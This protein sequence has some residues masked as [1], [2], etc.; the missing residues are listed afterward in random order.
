MAQSDTD[1]PA[2]RAKRMCEWC[3]QY[4]DHPK[5]EIVVTADGPLGLHPPASLAKAL[6]VLEPYFPKNFDEIG[7]MTADEAEAAVAEL[8]PPEQDA[9]ISWAFLLEPTSCTLHMDCFVE[10]PNELKPEGVTPGEYALK[11]AGKLKGKAFAD[12]LDKQG[13]GVEDPADE[14][15]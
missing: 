4:D 5:H 1:A 13:P 15:A 14:V 12:Y 2:R 7:G 9:V 10:L 8:T 11:Q 6:K 3:F